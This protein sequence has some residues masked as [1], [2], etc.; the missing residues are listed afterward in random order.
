MPIDSGEAFLPDYNTRVAVT[1]LDATR[2][3]Y[4][5]GLR[6]VSPNRRPRRQ[7]PAR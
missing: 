6:R 1:P 5:C 2:V 4:G 7:Q 3:L